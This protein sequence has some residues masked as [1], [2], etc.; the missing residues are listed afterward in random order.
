MNWSSRLKNGELLDAAEAAAFDVLL[1]C[2]QNIHYQQNLTGRTLA[3]VILSSNLWPS[4][5]NCGAAI[6]VAVEKA[7]PGNCQ[8]V[9]VPLPPK[10]RKTKER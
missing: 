10:P 5:R 6:A 7:T 2:D 9:S 1:T 4:L 3:L 8:T